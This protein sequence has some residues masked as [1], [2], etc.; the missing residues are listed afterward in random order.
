M[1]TY[2]YFSLC[3]LKPRAESDLFPD[4]VDGGGSGSVFGERGTAAAR[5][6]K[7]KRHRNNVP[8]SFIFMGVIRRERAYFPSSS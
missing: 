4:R 2:V 6:G 1:E 7:M 5:R 3:M 8:V